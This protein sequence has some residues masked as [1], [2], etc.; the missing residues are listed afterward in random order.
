MQQEQ[1]VKQT[2]EERIFIRMRKCG[3]FLLQRHSKNVPDDPTLLDGLT[4]EEKKQLS[5]LLKKCLSAWT[6]KA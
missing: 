4:D 3:W 1:Q 2:V 5:S 6:P